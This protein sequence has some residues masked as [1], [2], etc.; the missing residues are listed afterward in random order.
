MVNSLTSKLQIGSPL[1]SLYLLGNPDHYTNMKFKVFWWKSY[2]YEVEKSWRSEKDLETPVNDEPGSGMRT[3]PDT[4]EDVEAEAVILRKNLNG[5]VGTTNV[6]DYK[7]R[8]ESCEKIC[9]YEYIQMSTKL[10]RTK[11]QLHEFLTTVLFRSIRPACD[12]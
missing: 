10:K 1:A 9:L 3:C 8:A 11:Q 5:Y 12:L 2:V 7:F 4:E 6:D